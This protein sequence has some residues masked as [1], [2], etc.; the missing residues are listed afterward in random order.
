M[1][2]AIDVTALPANR[3]RGEIDRY[4]IWPG[5]ACS[6]KFGHIEWLR[7]RE[8]A[9]ARA[10]ARFDLRSFDEILRRG[11][12]PLAVLTRVAQDYGSAG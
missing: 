8:A 11:G 3:A 6:Y 2:V 1:Q 10:G 9:R 4:C 7:A 5:Q 12:M